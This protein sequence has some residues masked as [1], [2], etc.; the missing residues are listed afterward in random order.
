MAFTRIFDLP[1]A[2]AL[3]DTDLLVVN[4]DTDDAKMT[5][6]MLRSGLLKADNNLS[7]IDDA[8]EARTNLGIVDE[9]SVEFVSVGTEI[10]PGLTYFAMNDVTPVTFT[11]PASFEAGKLFKIIG[12]GAAGWEIEQLAGMQFHLGNVSTTVGASGSVGSTHSKDSITAYCVV[13]DDSFAIYSPVGNIE[14][15]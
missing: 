8:A 7:D 1:A 6:L 13:E 5:A 14:L 12:W 11:L 10:E 4:Q 3:N 15:L 2:S 9:S